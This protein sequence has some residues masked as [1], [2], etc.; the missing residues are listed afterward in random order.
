MFLCRFFSLQASSPL[1]LGDTVRMDIENKI[2]DQ[3]GP[4][5]NSYSAAQEIVYRTMCEVCTVCR[6]VSACASYR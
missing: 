6:G 2:C 3:Q 1:G 5:A 4:R